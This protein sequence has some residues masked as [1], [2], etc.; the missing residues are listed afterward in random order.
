MAK[1]KKPVSEY[2]HQKSF[3]DYIRAAYPK[4][5]KLTRLSLNGIP[6]P[7]SSFGMIIAMA[8]KAG[9]VKSESDLFIAVPANGYHGLFIE[10]KKP[11]G[12][13]SDEQRKY[14]DTVAS[15]GYA[16]HACYSDKEAIRVFENYINNG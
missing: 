14:L 6:L 16:A 11:G 9:M 2:E 7:R 10:M 13:L 8:K 1:Y 12:V 5:E 3:I 4:Y 15:M